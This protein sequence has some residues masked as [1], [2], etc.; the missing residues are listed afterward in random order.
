MMPEPTEV[1]YI[2]GVVGAAQRDK[3]MGMRD[4]QRHLTTDTV[5]VLL[6][7]YDRLV[8]RLSETSFGPRLGA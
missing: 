1:A 5:Q 6:A 7:E 4:H 2:R 8:D 3:A